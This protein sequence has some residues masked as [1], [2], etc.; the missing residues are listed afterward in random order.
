MT[1]EAGGIY[2]TDVDGGFGYF[3]VLAL[4]PLY[5]EALRVLKGRYAQRPADLPAL[6]GSAPAADVLAPCRSLVQN[7]RR[8]GQLPVQA[9]PRFRIPIRGRDGE[10]LYWWIWDGETIEPAGGDAVRG[11]P[12]REILGPDDVRAFWD[13]PV[14]E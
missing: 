11:M 9:F 7:A 5:P 3:A 8:A 2:E 14:Q 10:T 6:F 12:T 13:T 1:I 4:H